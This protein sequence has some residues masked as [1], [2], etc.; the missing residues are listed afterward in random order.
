MY[1]VG[2][3]IKIHRNKKKWSQKQLAHLAKCSISTISKLEQGKQEPSPELLLRIF[4]ALE[5][6]AL[7]KENKPIRFQQLSNWLKSIAHRQYE[8]ADSHYQHLKDFPIACFGNQKEQ[9]HLCH[10][11][12]AL[13]YCDLEK[14]E[15]YLPHVISYTEVLASPVSYPYLKAVGYYFMLKRHFIHALTYLNKAAESY[16]KQLEHDGE[17]HLYYANTYYHMKKH[18]RTH[19]HA[20]KAFQLFQN[21]WNTANMVLSRLLL[22][23]NSFV[24]R[25]LAHHHLT[26]E[27]QTM[28]D[29]DGKSNHYFIYYVLGMVHAD[30]KDYESA[31]KYSK[32]NLRQSAQG[33]TL[34]L[35]AMLFAAYIYLLR[36][37]RD[38]A[39][40]VIQTAEKS[41][42]S[43]A[44]EYQF[45][46]LKGIAK[47]TYHSELFLQ[48]LKDKVLPFFERTG[49]WMSIDYCHDILGY[50]TYHKHNYKAAA[51]HYFVHRRDVVI[52]H[53]LT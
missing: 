40:H 37:E 19:E 32:L 33:L 48:R 5:L 22:M 18:A 38:K 28:L 16:P 35:N 11:R 14:A 50:V 7:A 31:L 43:K 15:R 51:N 47:R 46:I 41:K 42:L 9:R 52:N 6:E 27:L 53:L 44:F 10:F 23:I 4:Q 12:Y 8:S 30:K 20:A 13:L 24:D 17:L 29:N 3:I 45:F 36:K 49:D 34:K 1:E 39:I 2:R 26:S 21:S 25:T